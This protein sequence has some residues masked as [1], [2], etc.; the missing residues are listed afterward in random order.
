MAL[1]LVPKDSAEITA[2]SVKDSK[3]EITWS[4]KVR[5]VTNAYQIGKAVGV[6]VIPK[7]ATA[8]SVKEAIIKEAGS[9]NYD[10]VFMGATKRSKYSPSI[11]GNIG[12]YVLKKSPVP[13]IVAALEEKTYPYERILVPVSDQVNT[14]SSLAFSLMLKRSTGAVLILAD[15]TSHNIGKRGT[16]KTFF[17]NI[18][19][20]VEQYGSD[21]TVVKGGDST[22]IVT[23]TTGLIHEYKPDAVVLGVKPLDSG[24]VRLSSNLKAIAKSVTTDML[25]VKR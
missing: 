22:D 23:D 15:L 17:T 21:V 4:D 16:F 3:R 9:R 10:F 1:D 11:V 12:E 5:V 14:R 6:K 7:I 19:T 18:K 8:P 2:F 20:V 25:L 24:K 13:V